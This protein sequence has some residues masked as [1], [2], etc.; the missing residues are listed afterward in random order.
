MP[1]A[2]LYFDLGKV[3][4][5]FDLEVMCRQMGEVA[6]LEPAKV[7]EALFAGHL[8]RQ[9]E[10]GEITSREFYEAFCRA[11]GASADCDAL[12][13]AGSDIFTV[14]ATMLPVVSHLRRAG[15]RL[16]ILSNTCEGHW[17]HCRRRFRILQDTFEQYALSY[18]LRAAKPD[19]AIYLAA[20]KLAGVEPREI[21]FTDDIAGHVEGAKAVG[22]DAVQ[23]LATPQLVDELR[24]RG[25]D[26]G[27]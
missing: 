14:N 10:L 26:F 12:V 21:F 16:G 17:E 15:Y 1:P 2:F 20:A 24:K 6:C 4:L 9:Y 27:Y 25:L 18:R 19:P 7:R 5:D 8:Q 23:Y 22:F 3:L 11:T 13:H